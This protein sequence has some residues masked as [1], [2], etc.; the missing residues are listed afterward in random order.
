MSS[1]S[2]SKSDFIWKYSNPTTVMKK[3][4]KIY[5][6]HTKIFRSQRK[7]KKYCILDKMNHPVHFGQMGYEDFTKHQDTQRQKNYLRRSLKIKGNWK[8]NKYSPNQ[9]SRKLL[10]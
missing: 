8:K 1:H 2:F 5:G 10:W 9:L 6:I 4:K 7:N 3:A